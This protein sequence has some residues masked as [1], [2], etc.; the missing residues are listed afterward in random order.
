MARVRQLL[1]KPTPTWSVC[2]GIGVELN[3]EIEPECSLRELAAELGITP[4]MAYHE[5]NVA[6]GKLAWHFWRRVGRPG[7]AS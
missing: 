5:S 3:R 4:Q 2:H 1:A 6:L 7:E